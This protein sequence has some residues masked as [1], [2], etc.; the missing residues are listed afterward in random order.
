MTRARAMTEQAADGAID[1]ACRILRLP[2]IRARFAD[3]A[4]RAERD[5]LSYRGSLA[6]LFMAECEA[7]TTAPSGGCALPGSP[8]PNGCPITRGD[9]ADSP[10]E[11]VSDPANGAGVVARVNREQAASAARPINAEKPTFRPHSRIKARSV[12]AC[13]HRAWR[14]H[15]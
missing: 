5:Q 10:P 14:S 12:I 11:A 6:E 4:G 7:A 1:S 8:A 9:N 2:T 13:T 3:T 15:E